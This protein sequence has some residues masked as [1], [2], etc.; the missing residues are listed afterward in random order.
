MC[1][2]V[3]YSRQYRRQPDYAVRAASRQE[4]LLYVCDDVLYDGGPHLYGTPNDNH[5]GILLRHTVGPV[6]HAA[7]I[8]HRVYSGCL[9]YHCVCE[10]HV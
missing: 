5:G 6:R 4:A 3:D 1:G 2:D 9:C 7:Q 10:A 8:Y